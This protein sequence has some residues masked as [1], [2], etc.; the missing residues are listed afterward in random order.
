MRLAEGGQ[1][2]G[3]A[4]AAWQGSVDLTAV[5]DRGRWRRIPGAGG[6]RMV[7]A[8]EDRD[9]GGGGG[10]QALVNRRRRALLRCVQDLRRTAFCNG[11]EAS[12]RRGCTAEGR[13]C[14]AAWKAQV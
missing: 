12:L 4:W 6:P 2:L 13:G 9:G 11:E 14:A 5:G 10:Y 1:Q 8:A 3:E 7:A